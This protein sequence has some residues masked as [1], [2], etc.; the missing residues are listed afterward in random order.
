MDE[1]LKSKYTEIYD[2][3]VGNSIGPYISDIGD[4]WYVILGSVFLCVFISLLYIAAMKVMAR[5]LAWISIVLILVGLVGMGAFFWYL[6]GKVE[7]ENPAESHYYYIFAAIGCWIV[8]LLYMVAIFFLW[9]SLSISI[10]IIECASD[11]VGSQKRSVLVPV[12]SFLVMLV[13]FV[14][15]IAGMVCIASVGKISTKGDDTDGSQVRHVIWNEQVRGMV[16]Y[17]FFGF[18]WIMAFILA[19]A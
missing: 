19:C 7:L 8:A 15:W 16:W 17:M 9:R 5:V 1:S 2:K 3:F 18:L 11:F 12:F 4:T 14:C 6:D 13:A 10:A